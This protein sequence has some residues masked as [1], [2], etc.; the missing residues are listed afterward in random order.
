MYQD[1]GIFCLLPHIEFTKAYYSYS[2]LT[3]NCVDGCNDGCDDGC[4][5]G[6]MEGWL[7]G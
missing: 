3:Y 4:D 6:W 1:N 5:D 2:T 7:D